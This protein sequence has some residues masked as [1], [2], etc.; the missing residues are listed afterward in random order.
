[1]N[2]LGMVKVH[3]E[4]KGCVAAQCPFFPTKARLDGNLRKTINI[5]R[6]RKHVGSR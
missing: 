5:E 6:Y 1:M 3:W 4:P 2:G